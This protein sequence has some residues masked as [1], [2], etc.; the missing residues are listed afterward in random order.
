[1]LPVEKEETVHES[2]FFELL[3]SVVIPYVITIRT[4]ARWNKF[5]M[6]A[7]VMVIHCDTDFLTVPS[8]PITPGYIFTQSVLFLPDKSQRKSQCN[9]CEAVISKCANTFDFHFKL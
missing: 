5:I 7:S 2:E 1:M 8:F 3:F 6:L 9:V 4:V